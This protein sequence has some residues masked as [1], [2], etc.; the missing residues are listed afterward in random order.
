VEL[1]ILVSPWDL[2]SLT[3]N[4]HFAD[5]D[6]LCFVNLEGNFHTLLILFTRKEEKKLPEKKRQQRLK[7]VAGQTAEV[8]RPAPLH[9]VRFRMTGIDPAAGIQPSIRKKIGSGLPAIA[10]YCTTWFTTAEVL[11]LELASAL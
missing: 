2:I 8:N 6:E 4:W 3:L 11:V 1:A 5:L 10:S 9:D 7:E